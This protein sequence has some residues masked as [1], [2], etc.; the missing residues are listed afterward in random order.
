MIDGKWQHAERV[1]LRRSQLV[2]SICRHAGLIPPPVLLCASI[3]QTSGKSG[4]SIV[5]WAARATIHDY[6]VVFSA[7]R[8]GAERTR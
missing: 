8:R 3:V 5:P 1:V 4:T 7:K 2:Q 6:I